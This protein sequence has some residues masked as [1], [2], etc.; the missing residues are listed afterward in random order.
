VICVQVTEHKSEL[1]CWRMAQR[2]ADPRLR[3]FVQGYLGSAGCAPHPIHER[4]VAPAEVAMLINFASPH[5]M[6][7]PSDSRQWISLDETWVVGLHNS[8]Q[9][10]EALGVREFMVVR[11]YAYRI[12]SLR[13]RTDGLDC[14]SSNRVKAA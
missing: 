12:P 9:L 3:A 1:G 14:Q 8:Y 6:L 10:T 5:R 13:W 4:H 7:D 2:S 11:F